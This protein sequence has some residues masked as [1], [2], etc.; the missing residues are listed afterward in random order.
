MAPDMGKMK[1]LVL[2]SEDILIDKILEFAIK[3]DYAKYTSTLKEAWRL[4]INGL[5]KAI[6]KAVDTNPDISEM[7]PDEDYSK[8]KFAEFGIVE[9]KLHRKRGISLEMFLSFM[10]Y[11]HQGYADLIDES[12]LS[13]KE[14]RYFTQYIKRFFDHVEIGFVM[15]WGN[16]SDSKAVKGLQKSNREM[17]NEKN[18]YLTVFESLYDPVM[19]LDE[20]N[21]IENINNRA[22]EVFW[23][24]AIPGSGYYGPTD[25]NKELGWIV[26]KLGLDEKGTEVE[27]SNEISLETRKGV[28]TFIIKQRKM[29]D[30]SQKY[31]GEVVVFND[32]TR[33][34]EMEKQ[35]NAM[36]TSIRQHQKLESIGTLASGVAHEINNPVNGIMNYGQLIADSELADEDSKRFAREII[37]ESER[38]SSIVGNLLQFS[39]Q[40]KEDYNYAHVGDIIKNALMLAK[41]VIRHDQ[42]KL[43]VTVPDN[44]PQIRCRSLQIQQVILN[45]VNNA[46]DALNEKYNGYHE[47][48]I[49][50]IKCRKFQKRNKNWIGIT[51]EDHGNGIDKENSDRIFDPFFT[52]KGCASGTGLGLSIS[53]GLIHDHGGEL[54]FDTKIGQYTRFYINLPREDGKE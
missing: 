23:G 22:A 54:F 43:E 53:Y 4:S 11:Y 21:R 45:I 13:F 36:E 48:K 8:N 47:N 20:K 14:K 41:T 18:K 12:D 24:T 37:S 51:I 6:V 52:T 40:Q 46:K 31:S 32:I 38:I 42:I 3:H 25:V 2:N 50:S 49:I 29:L 35:K 28:R 33:R 9:A 10:K 16:L 5:S 34:I 17:Q 39:R 27:T 1:K 26:G 7:N 15:E 30:M 44:L 19:L